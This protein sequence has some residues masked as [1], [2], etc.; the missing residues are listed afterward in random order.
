MSVS[1]TIETHKIIKSTQD[2]VKGMGDLGH[3]EGMVVR[4]AEQT[5]GVGR[6]GRKWVSEKGNLFMSVLLRPSCTVQEVG[7]LSLMAGVAVAKAV[8]LHVSEPGAVLLK[9][10]NDIYIKDEKCAGILLETSLGSNRSV[11]W[12]AI[13]VGLN[14]VSAPKGLGTCLK[15]HA[16]KVPKPDKMCAE[17]LKQLNTCYDLWSREGIAEIRKQWLKMGHKKGDR[18]KIKVGPQIEQGRFYDVDEEGSLLLQD[19]DLR[20]KKVTAGEVYI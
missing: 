15:D 1:W 13:G 9:W 16:A 6:H 18:I 5:G 14:L 10:P 3:P 8:A 12:L 20:V 4:A 17:V 7:Q 2:I 11:K 19:S